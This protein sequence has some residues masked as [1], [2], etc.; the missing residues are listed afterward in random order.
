MYYFHFFRRK[1]VEHPHIIRL[2]RMTKIRKN[3]H[4]IIPECKKCDFV[5]ILIDFK[6]FVRNI[7]NYHLATIPT[8]FPVKRSCACA[9]ITI[10][11]QTIATYYIGPISAT[12]FCADAFSTLTISSIN[13]I[14]NTT[15]NPKND[16]IELENEDLR[17]PI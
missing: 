14:M 13:K 12:I 4:A 16:T 3:G 1:L 7:Q 10:A 2:L 6:L 17:T 15:P 11:S 9:F 8:R 5:R